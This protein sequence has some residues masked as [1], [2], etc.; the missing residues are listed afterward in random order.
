[1]TFSGIHVN[2]S[3]SD[4]LLKAEF[5][6]QEDDD[7]Q[8]FKNR[9]YLELAQ[10]LAVY[11]WLLVAV[12]AASPLLDSSFLEK[13]VCGRDVFTGMAS[14]RCGEMGYWNEFAPILDYLEGSCLSSLSHRQQ[15]QTDSER[16]L[17]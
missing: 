13:G 3:F 11:G 1:M 17:S 5:P 12:S 9:F 7:F 14:V 2:Y 15:G 8:K 6:L 16:I 4:E 10:K